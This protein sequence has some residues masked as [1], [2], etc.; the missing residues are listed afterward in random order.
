MNDLNDSLLG[1]TNDKSFLRQKSNSQLP[2][3]GEDHK[4]TVQ[5]KVERPLS[6]P[7]DPNDMTEDTLN[8]TILDKAKYPD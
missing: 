6:V 3:L 8:S 1:L 2:E 5:E 4:V 7:I